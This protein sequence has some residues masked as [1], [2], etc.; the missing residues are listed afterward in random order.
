QLNTW[1]TLFKWLLLV[2]LC[3]YGVPLLLSDTFVDAL[4]AINV[5]FFIIFM[6]V[7]FVHRVLTAWRVCL[8]CRLVAPEHRLGLYSS[9]RIF[10]FSEFISV[11][12]P[13][14]YSADI[15]RVVK[16]SQH[17]LSLKQATLVLLLERAFGLAVL[18]VITL[19][20]LLL[21]EHPAMASLY[22]QPG[23]LFYLI[24]SALV[25]VAYGLRRRLLQWYQQLKAMMGIAQLNQIL[26]LSVVI[27]GCA[28][29]YYFYAFKAANLELEIL[30]VVLILS[31][32]Y[33]SKVI[34]LSVAGIG[35]SELALVTACVFLGFNQESV[36]A[37]AMIIVLGSYLFSLLAAL[38]ELYHDGVEVFKQNLTLGMK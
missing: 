27:N 29:G 9:L 32:S 17:Q 34:P 28:I 18:I 24:L 13:S 38:M 8:I 35:A 1:L 14:T 22:L 33:V 30:L 6:L 5:S 37:A 25:L 26:W 4:G 7:V 3:V 11:V 36:M 15:V 20:A 19:V 16:L 31:V 21:F 10:I 2:A 23:M 12:M